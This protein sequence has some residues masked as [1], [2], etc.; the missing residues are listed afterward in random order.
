MQAVPLQH[1]TI[2]N[3]WSDCLPGY[4]VESLFSSKAAIVHP[5]A[6]GSNQASQ[7]KDSTGEVTG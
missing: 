4:V 5:E 3:Q 1:N 2:D 7:S 6:D